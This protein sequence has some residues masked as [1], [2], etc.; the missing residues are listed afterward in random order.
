MTEDDSYTSARAKLKAAQESMQARV[1]GPVRI[2]DGENGRHR[3]DGTDVPAAEILTA[4][5][6]GASED[7]ILRRF[8]MLPRHAGKAVA[9]WA[10]RRIA[11][12]LEETS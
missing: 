8:P 9:S 4:I 10:Q 6:A 12:W 7:D 2:S 11:A 3:I 1:T 5:L